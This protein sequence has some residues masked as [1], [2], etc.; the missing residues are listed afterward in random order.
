MTTSSTSSV[1]PSAFTVAGR[2]AMLAGRAGD[3]RELEESLR[4]VREHRT[5]RAVTILGPAGIGKSRLVRDFLAKAREGDAPPRVYRGAAREGDKAYGVVARLFRSRFGL[6]EGMD[7]EA[8]K[9][10]VRSVAASVLED[11]KV[12]DVCYFL[13]QLL[14]L[15]FEVSPLVSAIGA[16]SDEMRHLQR[17]VVRRFWE[18]DARLGATR[19]SEPPPAKAGEPK[20]SGPAPIVLLL[21]DL[22]LAQ[23][24]AIELVETVLDTLDGPILVVLVARPDLLSRTERLGR[25]SAHHRVIELG[26]LSETDAASVMHDLL[27][28]CGQDDAVE[29][30]VEGACSLAGGN[31]A[32]LERMVRIFLDIGVLQ[33]REEF[34]EDEKWIIHADKLADVQLPL[35]VEDAVLARI[36][37]LSPAERELL[38]RA[39]VMGGIFWVGGLVAIGRI[40]GSPGEL[41]DAAREGDV[42]AIKKLLQDLVDRDYVLR[43]PDSTFAGDEELVFKHNLER[44]ALQRLLPAGTLKRYHRALSDWLSFKENVRT[45][46]EYLSMLARHREAAGLT[47]QAALTYIS[48]GGIAREAYAN[49]KAA[50]HYKRGLSLISAGADVDGDVMLQALHH[51]GD[52]LQVLGKN[53]EALGAFRDMLARAYRLDLR[54]K[55]GAAHSRIGRLHRENGRLDEAKTHLD[56]ALALFE[57]AADERGI[58]STVDDLGKLYWLR[59]DYTKALEF[60]QRGL[61]ARRKLGDRRSIALSLNNLGLVYQDSGHFKLA[62]DA[63]EQAL[64]IRREIGDLVGVS[65]T[66]NN[67]GTVAQDQRDDARALDLFLEALEVAK[68]TGDRNRI[69]LVLTNVGETY[70]RVGNPSRAIAFL[71]QAEEITDELGDQLGLA[72]ALRGLGKA[73]LA[74]RDLTKARDCIRRAVDIF[75]EIQSKVQLGIALRALGEVMSEGSAGGETHLQARAHL[76]QSIWMF[77][78]IGNDVELARSCRVYSQLLRQ[79]MEFQTDPEVAREAEQFQTRADEIFA[80]LRISALG[81]DAEGFFG[82][83]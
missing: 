23:A 19:T 79:S 83:R 77:E 35:T 10:Q 59:G 45:H 36:A 5:V 17:L 39:A 73:Y 64:R 15:E 50:E 54:S 55:G 48:A 40:E 20:P 51:Y 47:A 76:L 63:F 12:G 78:E 70:S 53:D 80:K 62:L 69:A 37:A 60:T 58:A 57:D 66:L 7:L 11:R 13:G 28:P 2:R 46:E 1:A 49:A 9:A 31:P 72:E 18:S 33:I 3:M 67:L 38:E 44:E 16:D 26:P 74:Q 29:D 42:P 52:V 71:K 8:Q 61:A 22:H 56:A 27:A 14:D 30:L 21:E 34:G 82:T 81:L 24:D 41:W 43:L 6:V 75:R 32:L 68:E 65:I 4:E 25:R